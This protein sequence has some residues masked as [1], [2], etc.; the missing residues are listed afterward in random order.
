MQNFACCGFR[1]PAAAATDFSKPINQSKPQRLPEIDTTFTSKVALGLAP[2]VSMRDAGKCGTLTERA[3][4]VRR[5]RVLRSC[6]QRELRFGC[7]LGL[8]LCEV[9]PARRRI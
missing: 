9:R 3:R 2:R 8:K 1:F 7:G 5:G 6:S 4:S